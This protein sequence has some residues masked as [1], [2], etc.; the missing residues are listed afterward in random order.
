MFRF[1]LAT[2]MAATTVVLAAPASEP[3]PVKGTAAKYPRSITVPVGEQAATLKLTG[4]GLRTKL[5]FNVYAV[6]SYLQDGVTV[7]TPE[8][9][10]RADAV[11]MLYL[12]MER[13]VEAADFLDAFKTAVGK[14]YP[15]DRFSAEFAQLAAAVGNRPAQ[16]GDHVSLLYVPG[17]GLRVQIVGKVDVT[18]KSAEFAQALWEVYL[19]SK[20]ID[21]DLKKGLMSLLPR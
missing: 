4:V 7:A 18:I 19:G 3:V 20:P 13:S 8:D 16:K 11:R 9:L 2:L 1:T 15:A 5:L 12:V 6:G 21:E 17:T 14:T 10:A